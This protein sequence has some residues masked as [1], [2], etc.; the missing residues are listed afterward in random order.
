VLQGPAPQ[1]I[2]G[3][4]D[5]PSVVSEQTGA[6]RLVYNSDD[7]RGLG[8]YR[9]SMSNMKILNPD[10]I[11]ESLVKVI[12]HA[13]KFHVLLPFVDATGGMPEYRSLGHPIEQSTIKVRDLTALSSAMQAR[14]QGAAVW[15]IMFT[16]PWLLPRSEGDTIL[17]AKAAARR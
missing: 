3:H 9:R 1:Q 16:T 14:A 13:G 12:E 2:K 7:I 4:L 15:F 8:T 17:K 5:R 11:D 6:Q 10:D